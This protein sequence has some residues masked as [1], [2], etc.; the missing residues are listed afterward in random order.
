MRTSAR[1]GDASTFQTVHAMTHTTFDAD[2]F[3]N[4]FLLLL[5]A[6]ISVIFL[7]MIRHFLMVIL[8]AAILSGL[9]HPLYRRFTT[10]LRGR[11]RLASA[12]TLLVVFLGIVAPLIG[13]LTIVVAQAVEVSQAA[14]PWIQQQLSNTSDLDLLLAR[15]PFWDAIAPYH[16]QLLEKAGEV[17]GYI[18]SFLVSSLAA[19]TRGTVVFFFMLFVMLYAMY[20]F[21][22]DGR[23][24]LDK[25]LYYMPLTAKDENRMVERFV[26]VTR[27]TVKGTLIIGIVQGTLAGLAF[28]VA[29]IHAAVFWGTIMA[30]LSVIPGVGAALVWAPAVI[31]LVVIGSTG[32]A[33][34]LFIW[35]AGLVGTVD[36]VLRPWLVGKDTKMPD[37]LILVSTL[38]GIVLFGAVG[39]IIGPIIAALFL[40]VWDIYGTTFKDILPPVP[41][42]T[43]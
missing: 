19:T 16:N 40:T 39:V 6:G 15:I 38:G 43:K 13:L 23:V 8:L 7:V 12:S 42:A 20:F 24:V 22:V 4:A 33:I 41:P 10:M 11:Q 17:V 31:Y 3:R 26:S 35:C 34:G 25:I 37:L 1:P 27:A 14:T 36:N 9:A 30:V 29:G 28:W 2:R 32:A 21:L 18:G 5:V